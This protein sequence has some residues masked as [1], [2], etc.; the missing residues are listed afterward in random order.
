ME[1]QQD[2]IPNQLNV[3]VKNFKKIQSNKIIKK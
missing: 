1:K 2:P 3:K